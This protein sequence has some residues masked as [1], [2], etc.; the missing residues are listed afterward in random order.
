MPPRRTPSAAVARAAARLAR[1][2]TVALA[3]A[4][5]LALGA[6]P[7]ALAATSAGR[8]RAPVP[9]PVLG[10]FH[11]DPAD[12]YRAGQRRGV[13]LMAPRGAAVRSACAGLVTAAGRVPGRGRGVTV[14]CGSLVATHLGLAGL[15]VRRGQAVASGA[16]IGTAL[17]PSVRLGARRAGRRHGYLDPAVLLGAPGGPRPGPVVAPGRGPRALGRPSGPWPG[18][19]PVAP[20]GPAPFPR[21]RPVG[22]PAR[23][24]PATAPVRPGA[25]P[26][27]AAPRPS[28]LAWLGVGLL[29][30]ALPAGGVL[31]RG[32]G[33]RRRTRAA[34]PG[35]SAPAAAG[36]RGPGR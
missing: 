2:A 30:V 11:F 24:A 10:A 8:W 14:R 1:S 15:R 19:S 36:G 35:A 27:L 16:P 7:R 26:R 21:V 25:P 34:G 20:L 6:A 23:H 22:R 29:A 4:L 31:R 9:G 33:R 3:T 18:A 28:A 17:G 13:D 32:A 5:L 12:P